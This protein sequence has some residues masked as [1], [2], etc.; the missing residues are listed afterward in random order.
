MAAQG[1]PGGQ[2]PGPALA[3]QFFEAQPNFW[4][5]EVA[6]S[7]KQ[8]FS[9]EDFLQ[10][11]LEFI[12]LN[13]TAATPDTEK[14]TSITANLRGEARQWWLEDYPFLKGK[15]EALRVKTDYEHFQR[16]FKKKY[17]KDNRQEDASINWTAFSMVKHEDT[18]SF[19]T[20]I[21]TAAYKYALL[22]KH[23]NND[24]APTMDTLFPPVNDQHPSY[25]L[26]EACRL[27]FPHGD[28]ITNGRGHDIEAWVY[29]CA[30]RYRMEGIA[31]H[32]ERYN[33]ALVIRVA[34]NGMPAGAIKTKIATMLDEE[35][36]VTAAIDRAEQMEKLE[37]STKGR[38]NINQVATIH[39]H[40]N[41]FEAV[42]YSQEYLAAISSQVEAMGKTY[43]KSKGPTRKKPD[44]RPLVRCAFC[45]KPG[46]HERECYSKANGKPRTPVGT[47]P[48]ARRPA[49]VARIDVRTDSTSKEGGTN[50]PST[51]GNMSSILTKDAD[52]KLNCQLVW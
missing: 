9:A 44:S 45:Q 31:D 21:H 41:D 37:S 8:T 25:A 1:A 48:P 22:C 39:G 18:S 43:H 51:E 33:R 32:Q 20:R 3:R 23:A 40:S 13:S 11:H 49:R 35:A 24:L 19:M 34:L 6:P 14:I 50:T 28:F 27:A 5:K 12:T 7:N 38:H 30:G 47:L 42:P 15:V 36:A 16:I 2:N 46:H 4:G 29:E 10:R 17:F 26:N 52:P